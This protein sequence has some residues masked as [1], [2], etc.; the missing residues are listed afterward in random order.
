MIN[1]IT[2]YIKDGM[3]FEAKDG[4]KGYIY[5][6][7]F[8]I[9]IRDRIVFKIVDVDGTDRGVYI[10]NLCMLYHDFERIGTLVFNQPNPKERFYSKLGTVISSNTPKSSLVYI[11]E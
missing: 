9:A 5:D 3:F 1:S 8:D 2:D 10:N 4:S 6:V 7:S 11:A